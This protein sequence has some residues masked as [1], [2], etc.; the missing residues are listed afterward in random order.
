[1]ITITDKLS[2]QLMCSDR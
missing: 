1:V 2:H